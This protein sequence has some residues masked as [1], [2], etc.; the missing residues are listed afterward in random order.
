[1]TTPTQPERAD[2][3]PT[4]AQSE[5][6]AALRR[7]NWLYVY[8]P[9]IFASLMVFSLVSLLLWGTFST[10]VVGTQEFA[11]SLADIILVLTIMPLLLLCAIPSALAIGLVVYRRQNRESRPSHGW[12]LR[13]LWRLDNLV[14]RIHDGTEQTLPKV[15][16]P[17]ISGH[18]WAA[19]WQALTAQVKKTLGEFENDS[20]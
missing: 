16:G 13:L 2:Y 4:A 17:L 11:S 9:V 1:M 15:V 7:F 12:L 18:A 3:Q 10:S 14:A 20:T 6:A 19:Y 8:V 5:R